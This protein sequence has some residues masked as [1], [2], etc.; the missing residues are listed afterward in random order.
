LEDRTQPSGFAGLGAAARFGVLG[1]QG[2]HVDN[3][4]VVVT[5]DEAV[6]QGGQLTNS[7]R[8]TVTGDVFEFADKE[9][10]GR[11]ALGGMLRVDPDLLTRADADALA[12]S[13]AAAALA[14]TQTLG[15]VT[16]PTTVTGNGGLNVI[17]VNGDVKASLTLSGTA[18]DVFVVNVTGG[19]DLG[20][21]AVLGLAGG[22]TAGHVLYN[23]TGARGAVHAHA[24]SV[25]NG[26]LL[27][28]H[29]S[30]GL[31]GT[32]NGEVIGGGSRISLRGGAQVNEVPFAVAAAPAAGA[33]LSGT[34]FLDGNHDGVQQAGETGILGIQVNLTGTDVNGNAVFFSTSTDVDGHFSFAD[35]L[36]GTYAITEVQPPFGSLVSGLVTVGTVNGHT[37]G[38]V[39]GGNAVGGIVLHS[40]D[41]GVGYVFAETFGGG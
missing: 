40:G 7:A 19:V 35:L 1:L 27:A 28:P 20:R 16:K 32:V 14:P 24:G 26:T 33:S 13:A 22:V 21:N 39:Q 37:D 4:R 3:G 5:G 10:S 9:Y 11:G 29:Y 8:S 6:S 2:T 34:V 25:V 18:S 12:A 23:F 31:A 30:F 41:S 38:T 15:S 17:A 36:P